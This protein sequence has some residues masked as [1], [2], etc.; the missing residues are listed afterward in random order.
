[1]RIFCV[2]YCTCML[3]TVSNQMSPRATAC[4]FSQHRRPCALYCAPQTSMCV[5]CT[6]CNVHIV[7]QSNVTNCSQ[8]KPICASHCH[9]LQ[10][11]LLPL[12]SMCNC[13]T[14]S[15][16]SCL[17]LQCS[18][19]FNWN[20]Y[21]AFHFFALLFIVSTNTELKWALHLYLLVGSRSLFSV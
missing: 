15:S 17:T 4:G 10:Q 9:H 5:Q 16:T 3:C 14:G 19:V 12:M 13:S 1:M 7:Q 18:D 11:T 21:S 2:H 6:V 8:Y 20:E